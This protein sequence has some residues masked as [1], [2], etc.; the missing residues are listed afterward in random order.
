MVATTTEVLMNM[1]TRPGVSYPVLVPNVKGLENLLQLHHPSAPSQPIVSEIAVFTAASDSFNKANTNKTVA[2]SLVELEKVVRLAKEKGLKVRGYMS[3][4]ITCPFEGTID[5]KRV[6]DVGRDLLQM[7]CY[8][9]SLGD[10]VGTGTER[11]V[12]VLMD[13]VEKGTTHS[14]RRGEFGSNAK[15]ERITEPLASGPC[16]FT[17]HLTMKVL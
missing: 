2:A 4:V 9:V 17:E 13:E 3:T 7:G 16:E 5:P 14:K 10:T 1:K 15:L 12:R 11:T 8:E 6:V